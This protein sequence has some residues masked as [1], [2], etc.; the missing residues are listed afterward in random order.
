MLSLNTA[1]PEVRALQDRLRQLGFNPGASD[2]SFG[3]ATQAAVMAFQRREGLVADGVVGSRTAAALGL[4]A[5]PEIRSVLPGVTVSIVSQMFPA[6]PV[7]N[8]QQNL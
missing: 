3:P 8:I 7:R 4:I 6:T 5:Q 1:G 2:G